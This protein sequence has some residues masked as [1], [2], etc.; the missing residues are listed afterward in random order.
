MGFG[1]FLV[2][3]AHASPMD[4]Y[5][6]GARRMGRASSG[7]ALPDGFDA[8]LTNPAALPGIVHPE[9]GIGFVLAQSNFYD[10]PP[11]YWDTNQDGRID[12][13]D[14][15]LT[16]N[17]DAD[18]IHGVMIGATRPFGPKVAGGV[19]LFVPAERLFRLQ[20]FEP[21][22]PTYFLYGN[23]TQRYELGGGLA[24]RP[25]AGLAIGGGLQ[26]IPRARYRLDATLDVV[27]SG[28]EDTT[29]EASDVVGLSLDV[30]TM[31]LDVVAGFSP[32]VSLHWDAGQAIP[33]LAGLQLA[34]AWRGS[35]GLPVDVSVNLQANVGTEDL[36][37]LDDVVVPLVLALD[38]GVFDHYVPETF[39]LGGAYTFRDTLTFTLDVKRTAW[40][41]MRLSVAKVVHAS[42]DGAAI[43][44]GDAPVDDG[45]GYDVVLAATW[46]PRL[47]AEIT[48]PPVSS[49]TRFGDVRVLARG[50]LGFEPS[51]LVSQTVSSALLDANRVIFAVG[52]GV[53]CDD[54][55]RTKERRAMEVDAFFQYH[56]LA[57]GQLDRGSPSVPTAGYAVDGSPYP[58]G[59]HLLAAG[60]EW[61]LQY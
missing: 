56:Q 34:G 16:L 2:A 10:L 58:I 60:V 9:L 37:D 38:I 54:P 17:P 59:G 61:S 19:A 27:V 18:P 42:I 7:L 13:T 3:A 25:I 45:N 47:G 14:T 11:V 48:T 20:T 55:F 50:G 52:G 5:G 23:R 40:D 36:G 26:M 22:L 43:D 39:T 53:Q 28:T 8:V 33:A 35:A 29:A 49:G 12:A 4:F 31:E 57:V 1:V 21:E 24:W 41:R 44:L 30:H 6:F 15:P 51:P 32:S 46:S